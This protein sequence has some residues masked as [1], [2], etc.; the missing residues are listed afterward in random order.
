MLS[1]QVIEVQGLEGI[2][3]VTQT[4]SFILYLGNQSLKILLSL[5]GLT[6]IKIKHRI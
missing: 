6:T 5:N 2:W 3:K 1:H 4:N